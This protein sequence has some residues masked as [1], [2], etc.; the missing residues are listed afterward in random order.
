MIPWMK[1]T[2]FERSAKPVVTFKRGEVVEGVI[3][4]QVNGGFLVNLKGATGFLPKGV[5]YQ[6]RL[7]FSG[8]HR[9][10][11]VYGF[12][13]P[14]GTYVLRCLPAREDNAK[15]AG[16]G[17]TGRFVLKG[18]A[19]TIEGQPNPTGG[20]HKGH[21]LSALEV[22][23]ESE[24]RD[25][26]YE[27]QDSDGLTSRELWRDRPEAALDLAVASLERSATMLNEIIEE[28]RRDHL[29]FE[30]RRERI[31]RALDRTDEVLAHLVR[32]RR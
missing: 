7:S 4:K 27:S 16:R 26:S 13:R 23:L 28:S 11:V 17:R 22:S 8:C 3:S 24:N 15:L 10:F 12:D 19:D 30:A 20:P 25:V 6:G 29:E 14:R 1:S 9:L 31:D 32:D 2:R 5:G 18:T 21:A